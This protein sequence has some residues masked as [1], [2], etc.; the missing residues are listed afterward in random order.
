MRK[1]FRH[2]VIAVVYDF[3]GT[4]TRQ[5]MQEYTILPEIGIRDGRQFWKQVNE[6]SARTRPA[7]GEAGKPARRMA[8]KRWVAAGQCFRE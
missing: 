4:L 1:A 5:P 8:G 3:D 2:N 6:E 7:E